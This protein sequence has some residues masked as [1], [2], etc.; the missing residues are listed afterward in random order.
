[1]STPKATTLP[2][3]C[4]ATSVCSS[5]ARLP[6]ASKN[7]GRSRVIAAAIVT[8]TVAGDEAAPGASFLTFA[9]EPPQD[10]AR[11]TTPMR[12]RAR[13]AK[14]SVLGDSMSLIFVPCR[15]LGWRRLPVAFLQRVSSDA[16]KENIGE[17]FGRAFVGNIQQPALWI[18][19][20]VIERMMHDHSYK[21]PHYDRRIDFDY[22][23]ILLPFSDVGHEV[24][25][26]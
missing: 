16:I 3:V 20:V 4:G 8:S 5:P 1:M 7:R 11:L 24:L 17:L 6:V 2:E 19:K 25:V 23:A 9:F 14:R 22:G 21:G 10:M 15:A 12:S 26:N 18:P 13:P